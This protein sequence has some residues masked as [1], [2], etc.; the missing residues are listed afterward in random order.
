MN[1]SK[2]MTRK[3]ITAQVDEGVRTV[4]FRMREHRVRHLP[5]VTEHGRLVGWLSDRDL[6][7]PDWADPEVDL[8]HDYE[9]GDGLIV[10]DLMND[11]PETVRTYDSLHKA[12]ATLVDR[13]YGALPVLDK[14]DNLVGVLS[15]I[16]L[17]RALLDRLDA[18]HRGRKG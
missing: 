13:R 6:R 4:F 7:R 11:N 2:Y 8:A 9:L 12:A 16:D 14:H 10:R 18:D 17:V 3:L 1:V 15:A 5:V